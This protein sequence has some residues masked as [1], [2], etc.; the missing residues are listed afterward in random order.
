MNTMVIPS[1]TNKTL[2]NLWRGS[3]GIATILALAACE[4]KA[5]P[6]KVRPVRSMVVEAHLSGDR[7][8]LTGQLHARDETKLAFRLSGKLLERSVIRQWDEM[9]GHNVARSTQSLYIRDRKLF[10]TV[11]SAIIRNELLMIRD[12]LV[13]EFNRRAGTSLIDEIVFR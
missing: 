5:E 13:A 2:I 10:V 11:R 9:V 12:G 8:A 1:L 7:I 3:L 4:Q 6:E